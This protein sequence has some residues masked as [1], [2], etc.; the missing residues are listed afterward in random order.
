MRCVSLRRLDD[1]RLLAY[2]DGAGGEWPARHLERCAHCRKRAEQLA[3]AQKYLSIRLYR[4]TCPSPL[5]LGEYHLDLLDPMRLDVI[6]RHLQEC[7]HCALE[8][9]QLRAYLHDLASAL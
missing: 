4:L 2:L 8:V 5:E 3:R 6:A 9:A 7:L 1:E